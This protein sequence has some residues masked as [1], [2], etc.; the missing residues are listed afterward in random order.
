M[1]EEIHF[2]GE[3]V[4]DRLLGESHPRTRPILWEWRFQVKGNPAYNPPGLAIRDNQWKLLVDPDGKQVELYRPV[5]D[6]EERHNLADQH[7]DVVD[8]L[9]PIVLQWQK[10]LPSD[11]KND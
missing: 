9:K 11:S 8:R 3:D 4:S 7:P 1:P 6:P 10:T 5:D 2:D